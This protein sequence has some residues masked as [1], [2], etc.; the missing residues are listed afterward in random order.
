[1]RLNVLNVAGVNFFRQILEMVH[2]NQ[3]TIDLNRTLIKMIKIFLVD[4][5]ILIN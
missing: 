1:M 2:R 3:L 5:L 4:I